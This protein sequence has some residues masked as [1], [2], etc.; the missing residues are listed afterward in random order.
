MTARIA[1]SIFGSLLPVCDSAELAATHEKR[2]AKLRKALTNS[3]IVSP[4][5]SIYS[6]RKWVSENGK[7]YGTA[8]GSDRMPAFN[9]D[10]NESTCCAF[11]QVESWDPVAIAPGSVTVVRRFTSR[12]P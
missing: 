6:P 11:L 3:L 4:H 12:F 5:E 8:S 9:V 10:M 2:I 1:A 7:R